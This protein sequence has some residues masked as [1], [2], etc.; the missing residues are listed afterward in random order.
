VSQRTVH[1]VAIDHCLYDDSHPSKCDCALVS[2]EAIYFVEFK[3]QEDRAGATTT[4]P[5]ANPGDCINQ[6]A[7]SIRD[8]YDR[9]I[10]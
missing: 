8:F 5:F 10:I 2:G 7:S 9:G 6:L 3:T 4:N 1:F